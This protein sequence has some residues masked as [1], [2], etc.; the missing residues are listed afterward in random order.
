MAR[1]RGH[2]GPLGMEATEKVI[3]YESP[4]TPSKIS[5]HPGPLLPMGR[6]PAAVAAL[7]GTDPVAVGTDQLTLSD[8]R[9]DP[10]PLPGRVE[11]LEILVLFLA[12]VVPVESS[13]MAV[14]ATPGSVRE[15]VLAAAPGHLHGVQI[16]PTLTADL[17]IALPLGLSTYPN[18]P[19]D[20]SSLDLHLT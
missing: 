4:R 8:L 3:I 12:H 15:D 10:R 5:H 13:R 17:D 11:R 6:A 16:E 9:H 19:A 20:L 18:H 2:A 1:C 14:V 7:S